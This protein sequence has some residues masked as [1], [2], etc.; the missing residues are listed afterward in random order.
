MPSVRQQLLSTHLSTA[1]DD[2]SEQLPLFS[3][4]SNHSHLFDR[5]KVRSTGVDRNSR[6]QNVG[7]EI[8]QA[9]GLLHDV[10]AGEVITALLQNPGHG[11]RDSIT[12]YDKEIGLVRVRRILGKEAVKLPHALVIVPLRI[13]A[14][15]QIG[16]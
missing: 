5:S 9:G 15:F 1:A 7:S 8:R 14:V 12:V 3:L 4:Q 6:E 13:G 11:L 16:C 10:F 2:I